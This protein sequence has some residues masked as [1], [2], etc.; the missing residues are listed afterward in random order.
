MGEAREPAASEATCSVRPTPSQR[1]WL[2]RGLDQ[3][4]G[5]LP[6]F[7][8]NGRKVDGRVVRACLDRG[9][10]EPWFTNSLKPDWLVCKLTAAGRSVAQ[11]PQ[12]V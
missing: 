12:D 7:D 1:R 11:D 2:R 4:G 3:P 10:A 8:E 9:W 6:L 5:K